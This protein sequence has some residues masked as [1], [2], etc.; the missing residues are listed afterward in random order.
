MKTPGGAGLPLALL[1]VAPGSYN[2]RFPFRTDLPR[3][4]LNVYHN[5]VMGSDTEVNSS[6]TTATGSFK[7]DFDM[8]LLAW[9][10]QPCILKGNLYPISIIFLIKTYWGCFRIV[11]HR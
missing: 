6:Y 2:L 10:D 1:F 5:I 8:G 11:E 9:L 3:P 4:G 7:T